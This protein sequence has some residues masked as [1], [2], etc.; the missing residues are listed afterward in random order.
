M[1]RA[2]LL[3]LVFL[4]GA[5][6]STFYS[7]T[8]DEVK[9][10]FGG[11]GV[12]QSKLEEYEKIKASGKK[13]VIDGQVISADAFLA[14]SVPGACY[15]Q[16]AV[17]SPHAASY[18]GVWRDETMTLTLTHM[19]PEPLREWFKGHHSYHDWIGFA[20]VEYDELYRIW[21]E[22]ACEGDVRV[23]MQ[24]ETPSDTIIMRN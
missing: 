7:E 24:S 6:S 19:L 15:T 16:N 9:I 10:S 18:L 1:I 17:F 20:T 11:G 12:I 8:K 23:A 2:V 14:F 4:T 5:C 3:S 22:G 13:V 21:P